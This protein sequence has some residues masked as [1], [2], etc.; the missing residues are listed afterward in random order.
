MRLLDRYLLRE[1][2]FPLSSCLGGFLLFWVAFDLFEKLGRF[3][4][5]GLGGLEIAR[6]YFLSVPEFLVLVL[7]I[8]LLLALLYSLTNHARHHEI[9]AIRAAGISLWRMTL[10]YLGVGLL[11]S[12]VVFATNEFWAPWSGD[13]AEEL[14]DSHEAGSSSPSRRLVRQLG[15]SNARDGRNWLIGLYDPETGEMSRPKVFWSATDGSRLRL[16]AERGVYTNQTWTFINAI[17]YL[18]VSGT[19]TFP[20]PLIQT[21]LLVMPDF[22]E[23][24]ELVRSEIKVGKSISLAPVKRADLAIQEIRNYLRLH[25]H[26]SR[27]DA[28]W[29]QTK[30]QGRLA[31][32]WTCLVVVLIA[33]PFGAASGRRNVFV[34][35]AGSIAI[36]FSYFILQQLSLAM[37]TGGYLPAWLAAWLPNLFF[38]FIGLW[39]TA[40]AR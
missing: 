31:A 27:S 40:R 10:P 22:T 1:L 32:P 19:N 28:A 11:M 15:F 39:L 20:I 37:G 17:Q 18:E 12:L 5:K 16:E 26:P 3:Q 24:P 4:R 29:L 7:P 6:Y 8:A 36:A 2:L 25:P 23:T 21:N 35:V 14:I 9:T 30:L 38:A 33:T 13:A 34:G